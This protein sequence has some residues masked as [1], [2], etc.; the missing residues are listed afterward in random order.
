VDAVR[1]HYLARRTDLAFKLISNQRSQ[2]LLGAYLRSLRNA[3][4]VK[5]D[6]LVLNDAGQSLIDRVVFQWA[7]NFS[8]Y[9]WLARAFSRAQEGFSRR[10]KGELGGYLFD[11]DVMRDVA[12]SI[13]H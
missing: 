3:G 11:P 9:G 6:A 13:R 10:M 5:P 7:G 4:L 8:G 2:G 12:S 1:N